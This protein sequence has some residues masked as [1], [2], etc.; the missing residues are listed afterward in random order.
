VGHEIRVK[1]LSQASAKVLRAGRR[2]LRHLTSAAPAS[3][4]RR[5][6][7]LAAGESP[8]AARRAL[9][10]L[11]DAGWVCGVSRHALTPAGRTVDPEGETAYRALLAGA[12]PRRV[13]RHVRRA[14]G[15]FARAHFDAVSRDRINAVAGVAPEAVTFRLS[16]P[17]GWPWRAGEHL[18]TDYETGLTADGR[19]TITLILA[20]GESE[21]SH[22]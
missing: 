13:H 18:V 4:P 20:T 2:I 6:L 12:I 9:T 22:D 11:T 16:D 15:T 3:V 19:R 10:I 1:D 14:D 5:T 7:A 21:A 17:E 8:Q